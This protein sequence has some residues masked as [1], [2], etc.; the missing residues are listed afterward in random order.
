[1]KE[2]EQNMFQ[3]NLYLCEGARVML[4]INKWSIVGITNGHIGTVRDFEYDVTDPN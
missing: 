1:M 3:K 4:L 2:N